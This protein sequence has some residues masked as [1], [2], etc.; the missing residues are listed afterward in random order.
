MT[1]TNINVGL[2]EGRNS[3]RILKPP[4][5]GHSDIFGI[6][7]LNPPTIQKRQNS[8][9]KLVI[10]EMAEDKVKVDVEETVTHENGKGMNEGAGDDKPA[11]ENCKPP[12]EQKPDLPKRVRVPPGGFSS[13]FW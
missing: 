7:E 6:R 1:S 13:G 9:E 5:G 12:E 4:G 10:S 2:T 8:A 3:S 11:D